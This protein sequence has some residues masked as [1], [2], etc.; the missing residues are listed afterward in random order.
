MKRTQ[1]LDAPATAAHPSRSIMKRIGVVIFVLFCASCAG[2]TSPAP[3]PAIHTEDVTRFYQ[4]YD[5]AHGHPTAE[6]LQRDYIDP[7]SEGLHEFAKIRRISGAA[8]AETLAKQP[9]IYSD[10]RRCMSV[11][12]NVRR[13]LNV[14]LH[15]LGR[16]YPEAR[17]PPVTIAVG[18]G[19]PVGTT[20]V[21]TGVLIGLEALCASND[22]SDPNP[23]DRFVHV[24][25][26]EYAHIQ[27]LSAYTNDDNPTVLEAALMEGGAEFTAELISGGLSYYQAGV[28]ARGREKEIETA[29]VPDEDKTDL[30]KWFYNGK[31]TADWL[32][33]LGYWVG[34][35]INKSYYQHAANKR[36]ALRDIL[37]VSDPKLFLSKSGWYPG[38]KLR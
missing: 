38:I 12:P 4:V 28:W 20:S 26:H 35:R 24:I 29:F 34:Y 36:Q 11:L 23:E 13:R 33:D 7:G 15:T 8:I 25:A 37:E 10:A 16:L 9:E 6:Q 5:N 3:G 32:G 14:A 27:Q 17:F 30:S 1:L 18:R 2:A 31:G 22:Q 21:T 19:K